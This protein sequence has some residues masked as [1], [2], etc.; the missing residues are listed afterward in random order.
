MTKTKLFTW[1]FIPAIFYFSYLLV[2]GIKQK[3]DYDQSI[4]DSEITVIKKLKTIREVQKAFFSKYNKYCGSWDTLVNFVS[5]DSIYIT[6]KTEK[7]TPRS[8]SD[9]E[10]YKGDIIE[11]NIDTLETVSVLS[12]LFPPTNYPNFLPENLPFIPGTNNSLQFDIYEGQVVK[13]GVTTQVV[14]VV[15]RHPVDKSRNDENNNPRRW[16]LRFGSKIDV[17]LA[18]NWE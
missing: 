1:A 16:F 8:P 3:I 17:T 6:E 5:S 2:T 7:I 10:F 15:D 14:E 13:G 18:G 12:Y 9:P 4:K 11:I